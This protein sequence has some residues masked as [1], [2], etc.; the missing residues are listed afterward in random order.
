MQGGLQLGLCFNQIGVWS[1]FSVLLAGL[2]S[3][4]FRQ[5]KKKTEKVKRKWFVSAFLIS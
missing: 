5:E 3:V 2:P 1:V 4:L